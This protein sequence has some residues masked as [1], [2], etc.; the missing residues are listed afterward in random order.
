[1]S[2]LFCHCCIFRLMDLLCFGRLVRGM[3]YYYKKAKSVLSHAG[4]PCTDER[5][6]IIKNMFQCIENTCSISKC[7]NV[8]A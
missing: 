5:Y 4:T 1:V 2:I 8:T 6:R 3:C 7:T